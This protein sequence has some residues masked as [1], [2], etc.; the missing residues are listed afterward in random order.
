MKSFSLRLAPRHFNWIDFGEPSNTENVGID[1][2]ELITNED[3]FWSLSTS[4]MRF[5]EDSSEAWSF[6][7]SN[8]QAV[9]IKDGIY[10][11]FD[12]GAT[13]LLISDLWFQSFLE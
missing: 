11:I 13:D 7:T 5:G 12:T 4:G 6:D 8:S 10:T 2:I 9:Y 1:P 3:Y